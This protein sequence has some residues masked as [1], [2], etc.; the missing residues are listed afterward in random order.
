MNNN[1]NRLLVYKLGINTITLT[2]FRLETSPDQEFN[3]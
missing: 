1:V 2:H 3:I